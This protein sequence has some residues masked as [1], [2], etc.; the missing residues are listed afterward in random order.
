LQTVNTA[1]GKHGKR[2]TRQVSPLSHRCCLTLP[3]PAFKSA[4]GRRNC[5]LLKKIFKRFPNR[6]PEAR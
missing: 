2:S 6:F 3:P 5:R 4:E 1:T